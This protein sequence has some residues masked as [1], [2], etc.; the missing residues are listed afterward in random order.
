MTKWRFHGKAEVDA[1][2]PQP[3]ATCDRCGFL[4]NITE[5]RWQ[6]KW[7]GTTL[8][9][10]RRLVCANCY[11]VPSVFQRALNLPADPEPVLHARPE[12]Y[13]IDETDWRITEDAAAYRIIE[14][15]SA[16][17]VIEN[18]ET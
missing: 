17:R 9:N 12:P 13:L 18:D 11:D 5:L 14:D 1:R 15:E 10:T 6:M 4:Y 2:D 7:A 8:L 3:W 16:T